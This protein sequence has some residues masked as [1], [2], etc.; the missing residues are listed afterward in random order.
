MDNTER[1]RQHLQAT[2]IP[3]PDAIL[4]ALTDEQVAETLANLDADEADRAALRARLQAEPSLRAAVCPPTTWRTP[5]DRYDV[6][7]RAVKIVE[8]FSERHGIT[9]DELADA[10]VADGGTVADCIALHGDDPRRDGNTATGHFYAFRCRLRDAVQGITYERTKDER[11]AQAAARDA[12][13]RSQGLQPCDR[14][15]GAGGWEGWP[16]WTC[17]ECGGTGTGSLTDEAEDD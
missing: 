10:L 8:K 7:R 3:N 15:G 5:W 2:N 14:C 4:A 12:A 11:A 1:L 6:A 13:L 9:V 17:Y 16:G